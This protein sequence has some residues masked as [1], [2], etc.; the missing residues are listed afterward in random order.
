MPLSAAPQPAADSCLG[1]FVAE[2][3]PGSELAPGTLER[4][5]TFLS[6]IDVSPWG[7]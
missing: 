3:A 7:P 4:Q 5:D 1:Y 2:V 6:G